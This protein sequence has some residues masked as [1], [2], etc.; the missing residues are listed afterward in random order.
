MS[1]PWKELRLNICQYD[2][3]D[4]NGAVRRICWQPD[5]DSDENAI[6]SGTFSKAASSK[7]AS[8]LKPRP[9]RGHPSQIEGAT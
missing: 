4:A 6:G 9:G 5:W 2:L 3:H 7:P 1:N 8:E